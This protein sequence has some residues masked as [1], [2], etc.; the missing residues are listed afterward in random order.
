MPP[1]ALRTPPPSC[2]AQG[3]LQCCGG[4]EAARRALGADTARNGRFR[5]LVARP[6]E[7]WERTLR[8]YESLQLQQGLLVD[9]RLLRGDTRIQRSPTSI[10]TALLAG[11]APL[12]S[13]TRLLLTAWLG[14]AT[15]ASCCSLSDISS[16]FASLPAH[17]RGAAESRLQTSNTKLQGWRSELQQSLDELEFQSLAMHA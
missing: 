12:T 10:G 13:A 5:L 7:G 17:A 9:T 2:A 11:A 3:L 1:P 8:S 14:G 16:R 4:R 6:E 15:A